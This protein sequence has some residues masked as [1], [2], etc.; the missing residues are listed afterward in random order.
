MGVALTRA[1]RLLQ[2]D[3]DAE[4][5]TIERLAQW[6]PGVIHTHADQPAGRLSS[7]HQQSKAGL[8]LVTADKPLQSLDVVEKTVGLRRLRY[9]LP[10]SDRPT[11]FISSQVQVRWNTGEC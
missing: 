3:R 4:A 10:V 11:C 8:G 2:A 5:F 9:K 7:L 1:L 6:Q